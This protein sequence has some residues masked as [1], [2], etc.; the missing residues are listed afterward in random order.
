[1]RQFSDR[2][3]SV[4]ELSTFGA[5]RLRKLAGDIADFHTASISHI[6]PASL[7]AYVN[8]VHEFGVSL[9][10]A[11]GKTVEGKSQ[12]LCDPSFWLGRLTQIADKT[13]ECIA[14]RNM[15]LGDSALGLEPYCSDESLKAYIERQ[16]GRS[17]KSLQSLRREIEKSAHGSYLMS[18]ALCERAFEAGYLSVLITLGLD[19]RYHSS[20][21]KYQGYTFDDAHAVINKTL[22]ALLDT[23]SRHGER[24]SDFYGL[25]C[26]E[27]HSDGCPHSHVILYLREDLLPYLLSRLRALYHK[28]SEEMGRYF[29]GYSHEIVKVRTA[30]DKKKY[31]EAVSYVFKNSYSGRWSSIDGFMSALRQKVAISV[32][33]KRQYDFIGMSG[34]RSLMR[35]LRRHKSVGGVADD[36]VLDKRQVNRGE[37][38]YS[39][40]KS[41]IDGGLSSYKVI[42]GCRINKYGERVYKVIGVRFLGVV[43]NKCDAGV[44]RVSGVIRNSS[45]FNSRRVDVRFCISVSASHFILRARAPPDIDTPYDFRG[46]IFRLS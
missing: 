41:L 3:I 13:T 36:L 30:S 14:V 26:M 6:S 12:R 18:K 10:G 8:E 22:E 23:L 35:E 43:V 20:S 37:R 11:R 38:Q 15:R 27:V 7:N 5:E 42:K 44:F 25:R 17:V 1:M 31:T 2:N 45:S 33:G 21:P 29:D 4:F 32:H 28:Q 34:C 16:A 19:G 46:N 24:G 9:N 39:A 40:V